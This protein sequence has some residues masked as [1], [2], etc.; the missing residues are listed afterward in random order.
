MG[1]HKWRNANF[2]N[3]RPPSPLCH[4]KMAI[5]LTTLFRLSQKSEPPSPL[6]TWPHLWMLPYGVMF[7][8]QRHQVTLIF[9]SPCKCQRFYITIHSPLWILFISNSVYISTI[10]EGGWLKTVRFKFLHLFIF[11]R[12]KLLLAWIWPYSRSI[13]CKLITLK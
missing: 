10:H 1:I 11:I 8:K 2:E 9:L 12:N 4:A 7:L 6:V 3:F 13:L 5:L